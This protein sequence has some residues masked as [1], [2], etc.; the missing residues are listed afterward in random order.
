[1]RFMIGR[2]GIDQLY[3]AGLFLALGIM[4]VNLLV[5]SSILIWLAYIILFVNILRS[6]SRNIARRRREN[7]IFLRFWNPV[8]KNTKF[9]FRRIR[10][11]GSARYRTCPHCKKRLKMPI[12]RGQNSVNCPNCHESFK[13]RIFL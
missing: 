12:K 11:M 10:E 9:F 3:H 8:R 2:Y 4:L 6:F 5:H 1:M 7:E 13:V